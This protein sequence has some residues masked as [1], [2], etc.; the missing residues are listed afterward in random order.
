MG[1]DRPYEILRYNTYKSQHIYLNEHFTDLLILL[2]SSLL[3]MYNKYKFFT[4]L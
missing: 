3:S 1:A 4:A 2:S